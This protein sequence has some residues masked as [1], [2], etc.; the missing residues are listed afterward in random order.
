MYP[1]SFINLFNPSWTDEF[2]WVHLKLSRPLY[3]WFMTLII[4]N[5]IL[6]ALF[7]ETG[8]L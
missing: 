1:V 5:I 7:L 3:W 8:I 2:E 4:S 6:G